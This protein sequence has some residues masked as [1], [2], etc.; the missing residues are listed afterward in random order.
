MSGIDGLRHKAHF[1]LMHYYWWKYIAEGKAEDEKRFLQMLSVLKKYFQVTKYNAG[2]YEQLFYHTIALLYEIRYH[3]LSHDPLDFLVKSHQMSELIRRSFYHEKE[4]PPFY[5]TIGLYKY[6]Y[7]YIIKHYV[8]LKLYLAWWPLPPASVNAI[9]YIQKVTNNN[10]VS[11]VLRTEALYFL[12]RIQ[13]D[14]EKN[15]T[16]SLWLIHR[17]CE[18]FPSNYIFQYYRLRLL[19]EIHSVNYPAEKE[20]VKKNLI[21]QLNAVQKEKMGLLFQ[22]L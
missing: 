1:L 5:F 11:P 15:T 9:E 21:Q 3:I 16:Q 4:Y 6:F 22:Q 2:D 18:E 13:Y 7:Q 10:T 8:L 12:F 19:K 17:L 14:L 20:K